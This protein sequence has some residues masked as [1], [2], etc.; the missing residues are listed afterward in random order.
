L[1]LEEYYKRDECRAC[2]LA[3]NWRAHGEWA[4]GSCASFG[5][6][7]R[8]LPRKAGIAEKR[9]EGGIARD[10]AVSEGGIS[11]TCRMANELLGVA[12]IPAQRV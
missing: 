3:L 7:K 5:P 11:G 8:R 4:E 12:G 1:F 10:C 2:A 6:H 9:I